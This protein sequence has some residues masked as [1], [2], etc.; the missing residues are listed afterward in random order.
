M[1]FHFISVLFALLPLA[2]SAQDSEL[3]TLRVEAR[4]DY[5]Q[6]SVGDFKINDNS[7]FKGRY[8]NI[9]MDGNLFDGFS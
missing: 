5:M 4:V 8:L 7:G 2:V 3:L 6:E 9:R 1:K